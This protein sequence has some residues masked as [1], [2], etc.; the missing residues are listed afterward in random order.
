MRKY[1]KEAPEKEPS[2]S[3][4]QKQKSVVSDDFIESKAL[5]KGYI[6]A[7]GWRI[8]CAYFWGRK[9]RKGLFQDAFIR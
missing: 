2:F 6:K 4:S 9:A 1:T 5:S 3:S 7:E 8:L